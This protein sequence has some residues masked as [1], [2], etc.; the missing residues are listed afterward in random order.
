MRPLQDPRD[1][2]PHLPGDDEEGFHW[3]P[4]DLVRSIEDAR[5]GRVVED[6][7]GVLVKVRWDGEDDDRYVSA[8]RVVIT[9][10]TE[11]SDA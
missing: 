6:R 11:W 4:G 1:A 5:T 9:A 7:G 3:L 10:A 8:G 2:A